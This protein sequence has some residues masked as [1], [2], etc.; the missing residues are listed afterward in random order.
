[1]RFLYEIFY[2]HVQIERDRCVRVVTPN[3]SIRVT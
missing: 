1:M 2:A 3:N